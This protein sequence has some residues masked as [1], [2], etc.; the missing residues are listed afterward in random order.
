MRLTDVPAR[1]LPGDGYLD[2]LKPF[3]T[4]EDI[5]VLAATFGWLV[6]VARTSDWPREILQ[7]LLTAV[8]AVRGL[9]IDAPRSPGVHIALGGVFELFGDLLVGLDPLW[10]SV[11]PTTRQ[12]WERDRPLLA[13][14]GRARGQR[15]TA[16]W[17]TVQTDA[18]QPE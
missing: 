16:A 17:R 5:H 2:Y 9:D 1:I 15:L 14:A 12:R 6:R 13:T 10:E 3:R 4:I 7:R 8:A 18:D 11:D